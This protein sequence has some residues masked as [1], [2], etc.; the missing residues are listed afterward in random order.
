MPRVAWIDGLWIGFVLI[1]LLGAARIKQAE[2]RVAGWRRIVQTIL[3]VAGAFLLFDPQLGVGV[4][5]YRFV[6]ASAL[7][8]YAGIAMTAAGIAFAVWARFVLGRNWS[9]QVTLKREHE[10]IRSGPYR[11]VR[12][13][14]YSGILFALLGTAIYF[15]ELRG[16]IAFAM[17]ITG[18]W[19][20]SQMEEALMIE[21]FGEQYREYRKQVKALI[22]FVL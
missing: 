15:G 4:L 22:P 9:S 21:H 1:W 13:P 2:R 17:F 3:M 10:L 18:W 12:H 11:L 6:P 8:S 16:F 5:G 14:I 19:L 7:S 20:K